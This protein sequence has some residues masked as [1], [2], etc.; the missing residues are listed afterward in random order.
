MKKLFLIIACAL[1]CIAA[2]G[3][4]MVTLEN[5]IIESYIEEGG[6]SSYLSNQ[7]ANGS[8]LDID[9]SSTHE[10]NWSPLQHVER[11]KK[12][13]IAYNDEND[14][15]YENASLLDG[16]NLGLD[17]WYNSA[18]TSTNWWFNDIGVQQNLGPVLILMKGDI[19]EYLS[20]T[21]LAFL[22]NPS[23]TA[24]NLVDMS[25]Q[26]ILRGLVTD[27]QADV[28]LG[29][30]SIKS[31]VLVADGA[32]DGIKSDYSFHQHQSQLYDGGYG[33]EFVDK[34]TYWFYITRGLTLGMGTDGI[35]TYSNYL[36]N[37]LQWMVY[38]SNLDFSVVGRGISRKDKLAQASIALEALQTM[39]LIGDGNE[40][41]YND[42]ADHINGGANSLVGNKYF[43]NSDY[44][45]HRRDNF[46]VSVRMASTRTTASES[47]N[48]ENPHALYLAQGAM[49]INVKGDEYYNI[50]PVWD[51]SR[52]PGTTARSNNPPNAMPDWWVNYGAT[53]FVG[54]VSDGN[55]GAC[56]MDLSVD[57]VTGKKAWF[58]FDD[59]IVCLGADI[60][61]TGGDN[62]LTTLNQTLRNGDVIY[63]RN[64]SASQVLV[65]GT[66][67]LASTEW[68]HHNDVL[69]LLDN[70][71]ISLS[72]QN[73]FGSWSDINSQ[74]TNESIS[75]GVFS[76]SIS[77]GTDPVNSSYKYTVVPAISEAEIDSYVSSASN[78]VVSNTASV[79]AVRNGDLNITSAVFFQAGTIDNGSGVNITVDHPC[80]VMYNETERIL[81]ASNP[82]QSEVDATVSIEFN[83]DINES[84][85]NFKTG[86]YA[87]QSELKNLAF[88]YTISSGGVAGS[89][90]IISNQ[91][92]DDKVLI[93]G[94]HIT[95]TSCQFNRGAE[96]KGES[97]ILT[98]NTFTTS[99]DTA[100][101]MNR[102]ENFVFVGNTI[103]GSGPIIQY[104]PPYTDL[105]GERVIINNNTYTGVNGGLFNGRNSAIW[106]MQHPFDVDSSF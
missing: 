10:S 56:A 4:E 19:S 51:W 88:V 45:S 82:N 7:Q 9:Y 99:S 74:Y 16:I 53:S 71:P 95:L 35:E 102:A 92:Y 18:P 24:L 54:G 75:T 96:V 12:M 57:G 100:L 31:T 44:L 43:F 1:L 59:E 27:Y 90:V 11:L 79:Q 40:A 97:I 106:R 78:T 46:L 81:Y 70:V 86:D 65:N 84:D 23:L 2:V 48:G 29:L 15:Q 89:P 76:F 52:I 72:N 5:R 68:I 26:T 22:K 6:N 64:G 17:Y 47:M 41:Q 33:L 25:E 3:Q 21:G 67:A 94:D 66:H 36:L 20:T 8:W 55:I 93:S 58:F 63:K 83:G 80:I 50:F 14:A 13:A 37:G 103:N 105:D 30:N 98:G 69:Y 28:E 32:N 87:G 77:H 73:Q 101:I 61:S 104:Y 42:F 91:T 60:N 39:A 62:I 49:S 38:K 85:F 34:I